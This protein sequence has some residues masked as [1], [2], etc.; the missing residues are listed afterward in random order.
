MK[1]PKSFR[2]DKNLDDVLEGLSKDREEYDS[3]K[4][5][6]MLNSFEEYLTLAYKI[7]SKPDLLY[8]EAEKLASEFSYDKLAGKRRVPRRRR[9]YT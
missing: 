5:K 3:E 6:V 1:L 7:G 4:I 2:P 8:A 9:I